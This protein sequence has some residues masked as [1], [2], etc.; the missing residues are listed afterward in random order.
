M[1]RLII[2]GLALALAACGPFTASPGAISSAGTIAAGAAD[3]AGVPAPVAVADL[4]TADEV[5]MLRVERIYKAARS[6]IELAVD[7]GFIRGSLAATIAKADAFAFQKLTGL[8]ALYDAGNAA[9]FRAALP[10]AERAVTNIIGGK[11]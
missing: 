3:A 1:K 2:A 6:T 10:E 7:T 4:T 11:P 8:R 9:S 5:G